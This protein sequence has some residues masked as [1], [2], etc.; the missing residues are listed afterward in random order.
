MCVTRLHT[1]KKLVDG[2]RKKEEEK[3]EETHFNK[4]VMFSLRVE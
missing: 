1:R 2:G 4:N 3:N